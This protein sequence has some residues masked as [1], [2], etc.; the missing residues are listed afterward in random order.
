MREGERRGHKDGRR[1]HRERGTQPLCDSAFAA[2]SDRAKCPASRTTDSAS[3]PWD[4][5]KTIFLSLQ[6]PE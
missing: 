3:I 5:L 4:N 1:E 6:I 2:W